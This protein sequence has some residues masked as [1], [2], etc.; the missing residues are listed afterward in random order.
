MQ[1]ILILANGEIAKHFVQWVGK[2]RI[3]ENH[4]YITCGNHAASTLLKTAANLTFVHEDPTS[5][6]KMKKLMMRVGFSVVFVVMQNRDEANYSYRNIRMLYPKIRIVFVSKWDDLKLNDENVNIININELMASHLYEH[7]PNVPV[8][9]KNIGLGKGEIMEVLVPFGSSYAYRHVGS[10]SHRKWRIVAIYRN[11]KQILP[12]NATMLKPNDILVI[13]GNPMVLEELYKRITKRKGLFPEPFGKNLYLLIDMN[14]SREDILLQV[15]EA[16]FLSNQ[17][18]SSKLYIRLTHVN[19][20]SVI[21]ELK[22]LESR[23][24]QIL[25]NYDESELYNTID[26]D[27]THYD[28]GLFL[29]DHKLFNRSKFQQKLYNLRRSV[30]IF[31]ESSLYNVTEAM[32]LMGEDS[33]ME[34]LSSSV[35]DLSETLGLKLNLCHYN[36]EGDFAENRNVIEHYESLSNLY[37]FKINIKEKKSNPIRELKSEDEILHVAPFK[38]SVMK[39]PFANFFSTNVSRYFLSVKK[40]PQLLIPIEE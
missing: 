30:Y 5:F 37:D 34:S 3:D 1:N 38:K 26:Y 25:M 14:E 8:I 9:A 39:T 6:I 17:F 10:V 33:D 27:T 24:I 35:F 32:L 18:V 16:I 20:S 29:L 15:N 2:S 11:E 12:T 19:F 21:K 23:D 31:G 13:M 4:Y 40:H 28:I 7:L 22:K 36:P